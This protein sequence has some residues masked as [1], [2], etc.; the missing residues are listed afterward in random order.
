MTYFVPIH[1]RIY[2]ILVE[3]TTLLI[4]SICVLTYKLLCKQGPK[5]LQVILQYKYRTN[6]R[7]LRS[8][9]DRSLLVI[10]CT[11][12]K[13][14]TSRSFSVSAPTLWND[15][16]RSLRESTTLLSFKHDLKTYLYK[17]AFE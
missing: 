3:S 6:S 11:K 13:A 16:P 14:F 1:L 8:N 9:L 12:C 7:N 2:T 5:Y 4:Y 15:L 10:P 17:E